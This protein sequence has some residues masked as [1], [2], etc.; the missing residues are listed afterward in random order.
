LPDALFEG[1]P[2]DIRDAKG[3]LSDEPFT[4][5]SLS[6]Q[7]EG[8]ASNR[9]KFSNRFVIFTDLWETFTL[10][11]VE[12]IRTSIRLKTEGGFSPY[13]R[14]GVESGY[15][16]RN[17][18]FGYRI[19]LGHYVPFGKGFSFGAATYSGI[20]AIDPTV[21]SSFINSLVFLFSRTDHLDYVDRT[22]GHLF[23]QVHFNDNLRMGLKLALHQDKS[24]DVLDDERYRP[25][26]G[27]EE[28]RFATAEYYA[29]WNS[30]PPHLPLSRWSLS[31]QWIVSPAPLNSGDNGFLRFYTWI[32]RY[33]TLPLKTALEA[34]VSVGLSR[35]EI[36]LQ[37]QFVTIHDRYRIEKDEHYANWYGEGAASFGVSFFFGEQLFERL[38]LATR[39]RF[40]TI[41]R[42]RFM[43]FADFIRFYETLP[44]AINRDTFLK[45]T[46]QKDRGFG[47]EGMNGLLRIEFSNRYI[48]LRI[49][50]D[51]IPDLFK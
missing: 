5:A 41:Y 46:W 11:R 4:L 31:S 36:P 50:P 35:G 34:D 14:L 48:G 45:G 1:R 38:F 28:G 22:G 9:F 12:G 16:W 47:L 7:M 25:N 42:F 18:R 51:F 10:N 8:L 26:P 37:Y 19:D 33:Q 27:V 6:Q 43:V 49:R 20:Q 13:W 32:Q 44:D 23:T 30:R 39:L 15:G 21:N 29:L 17:E 24:V 40:L 3:H 2:L